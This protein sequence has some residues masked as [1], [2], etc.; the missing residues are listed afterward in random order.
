MLTTGQRLTQLST[1]IAFAAFMLPTAAAGT[2]DEMIAEAQAISGAVPRFEGGRL[3]SVSMYGEG[4]FIAAKRSLIADARLQAEMRAKS[5]LTQFFEEEIARNSLVETLTEQAELTDGDGNTEAQALEIRRTVEAIG[6]NSSGVIAGIIKLDECVDSEE[7]FVF[8][9]MGWKPQFAQAAHGA[10]AEQQRAAAEAVPGSTESSEV[11]E[12]KGSVELIE[13][14][15]TGTGA[16]R[17]DAIR[18]GLRSAVAQVFGERFASSQLVENQMASVEVMNSEGA[19]L[20]VSAEARRSSEV[21]SSQT[22]GLIHS[23]RIAAVREES[24][25]YTADLAVTLAKYSSSLD[26]SKKNL[27]VLF[28]TGQGDVQLLAMLQDQIERRMAAS[29]SYNLLDREFQGAAQRELGLLAS[30]N[31]SVEELARLG[32]HVGADVLLI[33]EISDFSEQIT[34]RKVGD[35]V[36]NRAILNAIVTVKM[37]DPATTQV[38][39]SD[40]V[41]LR[42]RRMQ[43]TETAAYAN[44]IAESVSSRAGGGQVDNSASSGDP[45]AAKRAAEEKKKAMEKEYEDNW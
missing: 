21:S 40:V 28:P 4:T 23:Y 43:Q 18:A 34:E 2:C 39:L 20:G 26:R 31:S 9:R 32:N 42:N 10:Q 36:I 25:G 24:S 15:T 22:S 13:L 30:G 12:N 33:T 1:L 14:N 27:I 5:A 29:G 8:V 19:S 35:R 44:V 17:D 16:S 41:T 6:S 7:K 3:M 37:I 38:L 11:R 45:A